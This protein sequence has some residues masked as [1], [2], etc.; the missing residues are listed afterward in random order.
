[1]KQRL[2]M[3]I[4]L[5]MIGNMHAYSQSQNWLWANAIGRTSYDFG[6]SIVDAS[7]NT[8]T[9]GQFAG[10]VDFD[11][12]AGTSNLT[13]AGGLD[14][15]ISK[16]DGSGNFV[17]A[18][19]LGGTGY[20]AGFAIVLDASGNVY[21]T[22]SFSGTA[23]FD[24]GAG[25][26][27]LTATGTFD[28]FISKLDS[29]G[30]FV[31]A[32]AIVATVRSYAD[33][34]AI[35][36][37]GNVYTTG[38]FTGTADFDPG[39][40][41]FNLT[42]VNGDDIFISKLDASGNFVWAKKMG[43][44]S[45]EFGVSITLDASGNVYTSGSF[46]GT[47]DF[48]PGSSTFN[49]TPAGGW[50]NF[51][52]KLDSLGN[53]IWVKKM[54]GTAN[55]EGYS[56][57]TDAYGNVY[58]TGYFNGTVDFDPGAGTFNLSSAGSEDMFIS[59]LDLFGNLIWAKKI[60]GSSR[61]FG[62]SIAIDAS[63][64]I[65]T[66][67]NFQGTVDVDPGAGVSNLTSV[68]HF[69]IFILKLDSSGSF[70]WV[71]AIGGTAWDQGV[72]L[73]LDASRDIYVTGLF[74]SPSISIGSST[75]TNADPTGNTADIFIAK[76][77]ANCILPVAPT[78]SNTILC[79]GHVASLY[80]SGVG[81][82]GWYD[83]AT[84][85]T[86]LRGGTYYRTPALTAN[87]TYY[88]QDSTCAHSATRTAVLVTVQDVTKPYAIAKNITIQLNSGGTASITAAQIDNESNDNCG[89]ASMNVSLSSFDC[90]NIGVN[91][92]I[93]TVTDNQSN[94]DTATSIVTVQDTTKPNAVAKNVTVQLN[95]GGIASITA[96]QVNDGSNDACGI[97]SMSV[98]PSS[99]DCSNIG[100]NTVTLTVTDIH[101]NIS[102]K[103]AT[104]TVVGNVPNPSITQST[105]PG[106]CQGGAVV[107]TAYP[108]TGVTYLWSTAAT[109]QSVNVYASGTYSVTVKDITYG[110][111][112]SA[113]TSVTYNASDMLSSYTVIA[114]NIARLES[115]SYVQTGGVGVTDTAGGIK[116]K[117]NSTITGSGTFARAK[118]IDVK[119]GST[120]TTKI[121]SAVPFNLP[122]FESNPYPTAGSN[123]TIGNNKTVTL[124]D[125]IYKLIIIGSNSTVTFT[126]PVVYIKNLS[127]NSNS[128]IKFSNCM[129]LKIYNTMDIGANN[130][131]NPDLNQ[132]T[133][134]AGDNVDI[135]RGSSINASIY[136]LG[137]IETTGTSASRVSMKGM[138]LAN[139]VVSYYTDWNWNDSCTTCS[140]TDMD[141]SFGAPQQTGL[142][143]ANIIELNVYPNPNTGKFSIEFNSMQAGP[144]KIVVYNYLGQELYNISRPDFTGST[145][146][147]FDLR[148]VASSF[149]IVK[150]EI[151]GQVLYRKVLVNK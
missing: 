4:L 30:N 80:A 70:V 13:S 78:A 23:D 21:T 15:F 28:I 132:V 51:I 6:Y 81:T 91:T 41:T 89:I 145:S 33:F 126:K 11:P 120:V 57:K 63:G 84:G 87:T 49:L 75:L 124:T 143:A 144:L 54:G 103:T 131:I 142:T 79:S 110:C 76:L 128:I 16:L 44:N 141:T 138:F 74:H 25:T 137:K 96:A 115:N 1:M 107:L 58:S 121:F 60:G 35:D 10:T 114:T 77:G 31:W 134:Y 19:T 111:S 26:F 47:A 53:F 149:Y 127:T 95:S 69:D 22:G 45:N 105:L 52:S 93:L 88:V 27:N 3:I 97:A 99:F 123:I 66:A 55:D 56:I 116:V 12:G 85:G 82:L 29:S 61:D 136:S 129:V 7:G 86:W 92:V 24:P 72:S 146:M 17:W 112:A 37:T 20:D 113:N 106:F 59:K 150:I 38:Y 32:K 109:T 90:S 2:E 14:I 118:N 64:D 98:S 62:G 139:R 42:P 94:S 67:G 130:E 148:D 119:S 83:A 39:A 135:G 8:Y 125:S 65:Y 40:G 102:T 117:I 140:T 71:K 43:G 100:A 18:K 50:D 5:I 151:N 104:V 36:A 9:T 68:G 133:V 46:Q 101:G 73:A 122:A 48:D 34:I 108:S 147:D